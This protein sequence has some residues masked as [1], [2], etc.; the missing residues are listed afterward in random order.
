MTM[1]LTVD[2]NIF[3]I[4]VQFNSHI[5]NIPKYKQISIVTNKMA[6]KIKI[7]VSPLKYMLY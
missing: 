2:K 4:F 6:E 1:M 7:K 3:Y 5:P